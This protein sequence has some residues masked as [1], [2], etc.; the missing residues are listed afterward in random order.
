M[1]EIKEDTDKWEDALCSW[2]DR[3]NVKMSSQSWWT[4]HLGA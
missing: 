3:L 2:I 4:H 1:Q